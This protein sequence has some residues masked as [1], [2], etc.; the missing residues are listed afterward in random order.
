MDSTLKVSSDAAVVA[1]EAAA[2]VAQWVTQRLLAAKRC[3]VAISG[4]NTPLPMNRA[5]AG[6]KLPWDRVDFYF[7]DERCVAPDHPES[8]FKGTKESLF[9]PL[10]LSPAQI[11]RM[12][13]EA[14]DAEQAAQEYARI[15]PE[16]LDVVVLGI[17]EDGHTCSLFPKHPLVLETQRRVAVVTD[18]PKPP[19]KRLT[20]TR[21][22][23]E[24]ANQLLM[25]A[26]GAGKES[27]VRRAVREEGPILEVPARLARRGVWYL[28]SA[29]AGEL[30]KEAYRG[31]QR[32]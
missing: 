16:R 17:G 8:N 30:A 2:Q 18:S 7:C 6:M 12:K 20:L 21:V 25:L 1:R 10:G 11:F 14:P 15:L 23:L 5:L 26:V 22:P 19:P 9:D 31:E 32:G 13:G 28:D 29:A 24:S 3:S 27:A 4:G